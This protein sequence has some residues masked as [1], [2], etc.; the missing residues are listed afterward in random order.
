MAF[1]EFKGYYLYILKNYSRINGTLD[2]ELLKEG[3]KK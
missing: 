3:L 1:N 2:F